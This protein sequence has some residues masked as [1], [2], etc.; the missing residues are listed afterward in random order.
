MINSKGK[1]AGR[2]YRARLNEHV[3]DDLI[4]GKIP[5]IKNTPE[6]LYKSDKAETYFRSLLSNKK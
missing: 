3:N 4:N 5:A 6:N 1:K 2:I